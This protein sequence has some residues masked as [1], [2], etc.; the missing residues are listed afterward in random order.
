MSILDDFNKAKKLVNVADEAGEILLNKILAKDSFCLDIIEYTL[1]IRNELSEEFRNKVHMHLIEHFPYKAILNQP[2]IDIMKGNI[3]WPAPYHHIEN[4]IP[5]SEKP[6]NALSGKKWKNPRYHSPPLVLY[7]T[8]INLFYQNMD[9][10]NILIN[11]LTKIN[12]LTALDL[13]TIGAISTSPEFNKILSKQEEINTD[14]GMEERHNNFLMDFTSTARLAFWQAAL[15]NKD[16]NHNYF[17]RMYYQYDFKDANQG[18]T[19]INILFNDLQKD[20]SLINLFR[21]LKQLI[22]NSIIKLD[23]ILDFDLADFIQIFLRK[24]LFLPDSL[25]R[26]FNKAHLTGDRVLSRASEPVDIDNFL[27]NALY[28]YSEK[29]RLVI[30]KNEF[31]GNP[32]ALFL[33]A[34]CGFFKNSSQ[35]ISAFNFLTLLFEAYDLDKK[36]INI[37]YTILEHWNK[38]PLSSFR[39][40]VF[41][42]AQELLKNINFTFDLSSAHSLNKDEWIEKTGFHAFDLQNIDD[43]IIKR[44]SRFLQ[45][46]IKK[47]K[48]RE[49][50]CL[51]AKNVLFYCLTDVLKITGKY[52][53]YFNI[54]K[55]QAGLAET[56]FIEQD[57]FSLYTDFISHKKKQVFLEKEPSIFEEPD[58]EGT[59]NS[60]YFSLLQS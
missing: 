6:E 20:D 58:L 36:N 24:T 1:Q 50:F 34:H 54:L 42:M 33:L 48:V 29:K 46:T 3:H 57:V 55:N 5:E 18:E 53:E 4:N 13:W 38:N 32:F 21:F 49:I 45:K 12:S 39:E 28:Y 19:D 59:E 56:D 43:T 41:K 16:A 26:Y 22:K 15:K 47:Q 31:P 51:P 10:F 52:Q 11:H 14:E 2:H 8:L 25:F 23:T 30:L 40:R 27:F 44:F 9:N 35:A 17:T 37:I 7:K 60:D